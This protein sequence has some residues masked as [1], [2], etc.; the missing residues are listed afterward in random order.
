MKLLV[1]YVGV[2]KLPK[3]KSEKYLKNVMDTFGADISRY[4]LTAFVPVRQ[5]E[6][7]KIELFDIGGGD[8]LPKKSKDIGGPG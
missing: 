4:C 6:N 5:S 3:E 2:G 7:T 1:F 8:K